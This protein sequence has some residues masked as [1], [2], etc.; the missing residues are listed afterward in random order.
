MDQK[1]NNCYVEDVLL[2]NESVKELAGDQTYYTNLMEQWKTAN[3]MA[4]NISAQRNNMNNFYMS[5]ISVLIGG[6][7]FSDKFLANSDQIVNVSRRAMIENNIFKTLLFIGIGV[8]GYFVCRSWI[9]Q[10][11][12]Y[13]R[14]NKVKY[15]VINKMEEHLPANVLSAEYKLLKKEKE[16]EKRKGNRKG[17]LSDIEQGIAKL[18]RALVII[19]PILMIVG[20][21]LNM[22]G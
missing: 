21:W 8:V 3:E 9:K 12:K 10:I 14:L 5:L 13:A 11:G 20:T 6:V 15:D 19:V 17:N 2:I 16:K 22:F 18:F 1:E 7:L 4:A